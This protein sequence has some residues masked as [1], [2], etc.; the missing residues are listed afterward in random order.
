MQIAHPLR[1]SVFLGTLH[2]QF[3]QPALASAQLN[4]IA[5]KNRVPEDPTE[6]LLLV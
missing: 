4:L 1:L 5:H 6:Q 2:G 3:L